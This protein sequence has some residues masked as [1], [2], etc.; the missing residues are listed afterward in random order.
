MSPRTN[1]R[2]FIMLAAA[3]TA[4]ATLS[5]CQSTD[6]RRGASKRPG[7]LFFTTQGRTALISADGT[8]LRYFDFKVPNQ[9]TWQPG[10]FLSDGRRVIFL[11]MEE[12]GDGPGRPFAEYYHKTPTH[13]WLYDLDCD[14]LTEIATRHRLAV[15]CTPALLVSDDRLL[16]QVVRDQGG[17]IFSMNLDG[18]DARE[19]TRLGEGL[20]YGL[21]LSPDGRRVAYHLASPRGYEIW[22]SNAAGT[23]R[24]L[25]A[26]HP[27][28][29]YFGPSWSPDGQW[30]LF[31]DCHFKTDPGHDWCDLCI[32]HPEGSRLRVLTE[33]QV[34][35]F[36]ATYGDLQRRGGGSNIAGWTRDGQI[37]F[38]RRLPGSKVAW[39]FQPQRPD[40]DHF[41]REF[42]P[43]RARGGV[44]I[45][46]LNPRSGSVA[47]LTRSTPPVWDFRASESP[48][49]CLIV[50]CRAETG[51]VPGIWIM[52]ADGHNPRLLTRG[53]EDKGADH[54]RWLPRASQ[55]NG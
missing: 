53:F 42:K 7:R 40:T 17:Q 36:A 20:P 9:V 11:S 15:F 18:S 12:R 49:A 33:G 29:L 24:I 28:H 25:V 47:R 27:E 6:R 50:F 51:G 23:E 39:E 38:P 1:R 43:E 16:V 19:F 55:A 2:R 22:T 3:G 32:A 34:M 35:W 8:G 44:E 41:N 10:P 46:R 45:C 13:L 54:P 52:D 48:D 21:S 14:T 37:L 30:L 5:G 26:A 31:Q 4:G